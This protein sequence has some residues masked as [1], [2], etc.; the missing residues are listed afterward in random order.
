MLPALFPALRVAIDRRR[1][2]A[3]QYLLSG[4]GSPA[5]KHAQNV[6]PR[7]LRALRDF[8]REFDCPFGIVI[9]NDEKIRRYDTDL[10]GLP[11]AWL[12]R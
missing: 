5:L 4:A 9:N 1:D 6:N 2:T 7:R 3:G 10:I 12:A 8:V 11:F